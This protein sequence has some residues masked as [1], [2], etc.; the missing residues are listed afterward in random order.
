MAKCTKGHAPSD[1]VSVAIKVF[2][3]NIKGGFKSFKAECDVLRIIC[4]RNL[5]KIISS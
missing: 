5:V 4:H 1:G 2:N 3:L